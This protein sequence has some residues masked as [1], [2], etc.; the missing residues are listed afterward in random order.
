M[1]MDPD[2]SAIAQVDDEVFGSSPDGVEVEDGP[3]IGSS[4]EGDEAPHMKS[5]AHQMVGR[6]SNEMRLDD[7]D[8]DLDDS[9]EEG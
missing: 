8:I 7:V 5:G 6:L 4:M 3:P 2:L 1:Q 9:D